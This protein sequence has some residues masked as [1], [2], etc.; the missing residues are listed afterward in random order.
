MTYGINNQLNS[1]NMINSQ[2][3]K[4]YNT[5]SNTGSIGRGSLL[6]YLF[7]FIF[8]GCINESETTNDVF[9]ITSDD[10]K[11][12]ND[13]LVRTSDPSW[14]IYIN[15]FAC[16]IDQ[17]DKTILFPISAPSI[18]GFMGIVEYSNDLYEHVYINEIMVENGDNVNFGNIIIGDSILVRFI[19]GDNIQMPTETLIIATPELV[20]GEFEEKN[21]IDYNLI[22][23]DLPTVLIFTNEDIVNEPKILSQIIINDLVENKVYETF[24]GIEIRGKS[25]QA[26]PK[27]SYDLEL[28]EDKIGSDTNKEELFGLRNDDDWHLD[29]MYI[30]LSKTRNILGMETWGSFARSSHLLLEE[31]A[32]LYQRGNIVELFLNNNYVGIYSMNEQ[33]DRKQLD[34]KKNGGI[35]YKSDAWYDENMFKGIG[36]EPDTSLFWSGY[37]LKYPDEIDIEYWTPLYDF[38]NLVAYSD[39]ET[40]IASIENVLDIQNAIDFFIFLNLIQANDNVGSN[41]YIFRYDEEYPLA[42][43][44]WDLDLTFGNKNSTWSVDDPDDRIITNK[45][46]NRLYALDVNNYRNK[47]K[48]RWNEIYQDGIQEYIINKLTENINNLIDSKADNRDNKKWNFETDYN[49]RLEYI[50]NWLNTRIDFFNNYI[51]SKY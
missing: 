41:L 46:F 7:I 21:Y 28:W 25:S 50:I 45:I 39:D 23:T 5:N 12:T 15:D 48:L 34:L 30:D 26:Y 1:I 37:E 10:S 9:D 19:V 38:I 13:V 33:I 18:D 11:K 49:E 42:F 35:L 6:L 2:I 22:F 32:L 24:A 20:I 47:V 4:Y 43:I 16:A 27:K 17:S 14:L 31:D 36:V 8:S 44:P 3:Y 40:F 51:D 29:A